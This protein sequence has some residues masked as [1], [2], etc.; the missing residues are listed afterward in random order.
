MS[1]VLPIAIAPGSGVENLVN[2]F[3]IPFDPPLLN[4]KEGQW[5]VALSEFSFAHYFLTIKKEDYIRVVKL[6]RHEAR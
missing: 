2:K 3:Q 5:E 4:G 1:H 6:K